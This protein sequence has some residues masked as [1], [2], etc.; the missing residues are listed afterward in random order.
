VWCLSCEQF[1]RLQLC[2]RCID[3]LEVAPDT[4]IPEGLIVR[5]AF[6]HEGTA[7]ELVTKL[8][9]QG[10]GGI[11]DFFAR[12]LAERLPSATQLLVPIPRVLA[13]RVKYGVDPAVSIARAL[14]RRTGLPIASALSAPL[15]A[16]RSAGRALDQRQAKRFWVKKPVDNWLLID[17][18]VT[19][20]S[21][22]GSAA[23]AL[24][25]IGH[26]AVTA[27]ASL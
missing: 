25:G 20:G 5:A 15:W 24:S 19:S 17:D 11:A 18:V 27:T 14:Q 7:R 3:G 21:T 26:G 9:Y 10:M 1:S 16:P 22:L 12:A 6:L 23:K 4:T 8:K 13:R 2:G